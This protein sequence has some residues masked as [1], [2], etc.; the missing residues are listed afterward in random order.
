MKLCT[1]YSSIFR[2][3]VQNGIDYLKD[4]PDIKTMVV[5]LSGGIDSAL[6]AVL[7]R[8]ICN[9]TSK[10]RLIGISIPIQSNKKSEVLRA[11]D[12][13]K[14][15]CHE[16]REIKIINTIFKL[17]NR[18]IK[19]ESTAEKIRLGNVK[20]RVRMI[21]LYDAAHRRNGIVLS[22]DNLSEFNLGFWTLHG[23]VGD[24]G[25]IQ[26][27][28]KT[29]IY[30]LSK[31]L[32]D[33]YFGIF[34][35]ESKYVDWL[36]Y[37]LKSRALDASIKAVPTDG[38]GITNSDFD[39]LGVDSYQEVDK[40]LIEYINTR[41]EDLEHHPVIKRHLKYA[42]KRNNPYNI[43]R[44]NIIAKS[45]EYFNITKGLPFTTKYF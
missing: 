21:S 24:F 28:W 18:F 32:S 10:H 30:G 5:G 35:N 25:L 6:T 33:K 17:A 11:A 31:Y 45:K 2:N 29:E 13:G 19:S 42:F 44:S 38:L 20:A 39:Q 22:T 16:F 26:S 27:L 14:M 43:P 40:I 12:I 36:D 15:F 4:Y 7:A 34:E 8:E 37:G 3:I 23:D 41:T 9:R 1:D